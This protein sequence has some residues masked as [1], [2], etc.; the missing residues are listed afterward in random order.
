MI[1]GIIRRN[2]RYVIC[3]NFENFTDPKIMN[4]IQISGFLVAFALAS[5]FF[6]FYSKTVLLH[7]AKGEKFSPFRSVVRGVVCPEN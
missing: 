3:F 5:T 2:K 7:G 6:V 1:F 4:D